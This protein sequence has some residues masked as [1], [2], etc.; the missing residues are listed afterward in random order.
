MLAARGRAVAFTDA[1]LSYSPDQ[2]IGLL[3]QIESGWDVVV[4]SRRHTDTT[5][6]VRAR[7]L[8]EIGGRVINVLTYAVLLGH[9]RDT[10]CGLKAFRSDVAQLIFSHSRVDG[11]AFD[12]EVFHL[13]EEYRLSLTEVPV[14]VENTNSSTV[15][16]V[17]DALRLIRDLFRIRRWS[18]QGVYRLEPGESDL[19]PSD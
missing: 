1:D 9:H 4:G 11:F 13:V 3:E 12:V 17:R 19:V 16:V 18:R 5:T 14:R 7:R 2:I 15:K 10:Q 6:L 8:R